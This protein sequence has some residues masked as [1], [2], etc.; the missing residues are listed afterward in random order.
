VLYYIK[1]TLGFGKVISQSAKIS[2]YVTQNK[3]EIEIL[4]SLLNGNIVLPTR[5]KKLESFIKGF[6]S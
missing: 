5:Q 1:E 2:R 4:I 6:N 3:K